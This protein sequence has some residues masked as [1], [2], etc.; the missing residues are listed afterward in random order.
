MAV[1]NT[2]P[3]SQF[4]YNHGCSRTP[5]EYRLKTVFTTATG[6]RRVDFEAIPKT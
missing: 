3:A 5:K 6:L 4:L 2:K 1:R